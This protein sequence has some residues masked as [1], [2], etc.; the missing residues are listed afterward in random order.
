MHW[1]AT[2]YRLVWVSH[3]SNLQWHRLHKNET[4]VP[5]VPHLLGNTSIYPVRFPCYIFDN[6]GASRGNW[7]SRS[8]KTRTVLKFDSDFTMVGIST[9]ISKAMARASPSKIWM[10]LW[11]KLWFPSW[12]TRNQRATPSK[13]N[14][15]VIGA[16]TVLDVNP[17]SP[18]CFHHDGKNLEIEQR[19]DAATHAPVYDIVAHEWLW[20]CTIH[21]ICRW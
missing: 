18:W 2:I 7:V 19:N 1:F 17:N 21:N 10:G 5:R 16:V 3:G 20:C 9:I 12:K 8:A 13:W 15:A 6:F 11:L 14:S 4:C